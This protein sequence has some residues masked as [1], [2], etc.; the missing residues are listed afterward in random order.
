MLAIRAL[1]TAFWS[2]ARLLLISFF[3]GRGKMLV[4]VTLVTTPRSVQSRTLGASPCL[5]KASSVALSLVLSRAKY[6]DSAISLSFFS[7]TPETSIL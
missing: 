2:A 5:K 7:S 4:S 6:L 3:Y 1:S